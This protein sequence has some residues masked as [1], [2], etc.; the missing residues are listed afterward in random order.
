[1]EC[2]SD[3]RLSDMRS[4]R[5]PRP[6]VKTSTRETREQGLHMHSP[7]RERLAF[8]GGQTWMRRALQAYRR[9]RISWHTGEFIRSSGVSSTASSRSTH[10]KCAKQ[11]AGCLCTPCRCALTRPGKHARTHELRPATIGRRRESAH[12]GMPPCVFARESVRM[13]TYVNSRG[14]SEVRRT[15]RRHLPRASTRAQQPRRS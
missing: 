10:L 3:S 4:R 6:R 5:V 13:C 2:W 11:S 15:S 7:P 12:A 14:G 1:M 9:S 8:W